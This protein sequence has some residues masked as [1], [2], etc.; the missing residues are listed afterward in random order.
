MFSYIPYTKIDGIRTMPDSAIKE[1]FVRTEEDGDVKTVFYDGSIR[2]P[3]DF[4]IAMQQQNTCLW[5]LKDDTDTVGYMWFD[6]FEGHSARNHGCIFKK[7]RNKSVSLG[8]FIFDKAMNLK[9]NGQFVFDVIIGVTPKSNTA[10]IN[11]AV[12]CGGSVVG[13]IKNMVWDYYKQQ[14]EDAVL[15]QYRRA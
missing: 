2:T 11:Y 3:D 1:L 10:A 12:L 9:L 7:H 4:L 14:S 5:I 15:I 8:K 6:R 13:E